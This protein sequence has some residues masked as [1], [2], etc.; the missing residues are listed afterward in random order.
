MRNTSYLELQ[1]GEVDWRS[2]V[3]LPA[4]RFAGGTIEIPDRP[5]FGVA[6]NADVV[7][8]HELPL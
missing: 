1:Y 2:D 5:G 8:A 7:R 6:L 3:L 4:E